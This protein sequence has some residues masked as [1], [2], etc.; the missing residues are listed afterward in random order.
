MNLLSVYI[1][2]YTVHVDPSVQQLIQS[3][4]QEDFCGVGGKRTVHVQKCM[5]A[6]LLDYYDNTLECT[7]D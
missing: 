3:A 6:E 2:L 1:Y 7:A 4:A 5:P